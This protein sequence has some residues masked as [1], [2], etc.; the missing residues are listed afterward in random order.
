MAITAAKK[1]SDFSGTTSGFIPAEVSGTIFEL[2]ARMSVAQQ[3]VPQVPLSFRGTSVPVVT[4]RPVAKW[5]DEASAKQATQGTMSL[6][7]ITPKKLA[8]IAVVS[9]ETIRANPGGY[10][11]SLRP[12]LAEAFA[13]AFDYA[14]FYGLGG[15]GTGAGPFST[16][17]AQTT[18]STEF[19]ANSQ[20]NGGVYKDLVDSIAE[21]VSDTDAS[22][23]RHYQCNGFALDNQVEP[24]LL[25]AVDSSGRPIWV[26]LPIDAQANV[27]ARPGSLVGRVA[28][29]G[30]LANPA[31]TIHGFAGDWTQ[32]AWG[33]VGGITFDVSTEAAVTI[34][35]SLVSLFENNLVAIRAEAEYGFLLNDADAFVQLRNDTAS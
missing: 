33:V 3:L 21:I 9:A 16:Y 34:N 19:G 12:Q 10:V 8:A 18:K 15:D 11:D 5:V 1:V 24:R 25:A 29:L 2:A 27:F 20:A 13:V 7:T 23:I 14:A 4:G 17:L 35:G 31:N 28:Y 30:D 6:K 32:A 26:D 22:G